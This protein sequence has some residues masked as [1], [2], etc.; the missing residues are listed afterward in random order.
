MIKVYHTRCEA[1]F[2]DAV[3]SKYM[4]LLPDEIASKISRKKNWQDAQASLLGKLLL[5]KGLAEFGLSDDLSK[6]KYNEFDRPYLQKRLDFN[7]A[8][9]GPYIVCAFA[10]NQSIGIDIEQIKDVSI[11]DFRNVFHQEEWQILL[12]SANKK[13]TFFNYWTAKEAIVKAE[14]KGLNIPANSIRIKGESVR[15]ADS[16][17]HYK[18]IFIF[19]NAITHLASN[20]QL[21][22]I[23]YV[24]V[25]FK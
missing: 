23:R 12:S 7:I 24:P 20:K 19:E 3:L 6:L 11:A 8:H 21:E 25:D 4:Q 14:G 2:P 5:K 1:Q 13:E 9:S 16:K 10:E 18:E 17:W 22:D 15:I